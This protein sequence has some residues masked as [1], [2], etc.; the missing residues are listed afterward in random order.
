MSDPIIIQSPKAERKTGT[1]E[2]AKNDTLAGIALK[3]GMNMSELKKLNRL[4]D[5]NSLYPGLKLLVY[6]DSQPAE[7]STSPTYDRKTIDNSSRAPLSP[8]KEPLSKSPPHKAERSFSNTTLEL[9]KKKSTLPLV[10]LLRRKRQHHYYYA[11]DAEEAKLSGSHDNI[12]TSPQSQRK[13]K[14]FNKIALQ[15]R[16]D[17]RE[18]YRETAR[19]LVENTSVLGVLTVTPSR[20]IFEPELYDPAVTK[21]GLL[22]CQFTGDMDQIL[23]VEIV[24]PVTSHLS[25]SPTNTNALNALHD[26]PPTSGITTN[27][28]FLVITFKKRRVIFYISSVSI[29]TLF[30]TLQNWRN[31][32]QNSRVL[33]E[34]GKMETDFEVMD[35]K[36]ETLNES[37]FVKILREDEDDS[38]EE[39]LP[40]LF[41]QS[42]ILKSID[43]KRIKD[44][45]P[46]R[47]QLHDWTLLYSTM[48]HGISLNTF[49][50]KVFN[51]GP[52]IILI[53]DSK[54]CVFGAFVS[55][56]WEPR[57]GFYGS[58]ESF[59]F[60]LFPE[61][62]AYTW[63]GLNNYVM[64]SNEEQIAM[65]GGSGKFAL[66]LDSEFY[67]G[68]SGYSETFMNECLASGEDFKCTVFEC[69]GFVAP[70]DAKKASVED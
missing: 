68:S 38:A 29:E 70:K 3:Y 25:S 49:Y 19:F 57:K 5:T 53:E 44:A 27:S 59:L 33:Q 28:P 67:M 13:S 46:L 11:G 69:W 34:L 32:K 41:G 12:A 30:K 54:N 50:A 43:I 45:L 31:V 24:D 51:K 36:R 63:T 37:G 55:E 10:V 20:L 42:V 62:N 61:F 65:G 52:N 60:T 35:I 21:L 18:V 22:E 9:E 64:Y 66:W 8:K 26:L 40:K 48:R 7:G 2:V 56:H 15:L 4:T 39:I 14:D 23:D 6:T 17:Q 1:Y 47:Y 58:G 16:E